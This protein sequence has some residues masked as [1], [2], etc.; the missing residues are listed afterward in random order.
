MW[1]VVSQI[2]SVLGILYTII[3]LIQVMIKRTSSLLSVMRFLLRFFLRRNRFYHNFR[4]LRIE[5]WF[6][7]PRIVADEQRA[8]FNV[9][10]ENVSRSSFSNVIFF[11]KL[12]RSM[13]MIRPMNIITE[14]LKDDQIKY[15]DKLGELGL[16]CAVKR[17]YEF[18]YEGKELFVHM[19]ITPFIV[20]TKKVDG[21]EERLEPEQ[22]K[23]L[24]LKVKRK[25]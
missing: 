2:F 6:D 1:N 4:G 16:R 7:R 3:E 22:L 17:Q 18:S 20:V 21:E 11:F 10:I 13:R 8:R 24:S 12:P 19:E 14:E 15:V 5:Y 23:K 9:L 25:H